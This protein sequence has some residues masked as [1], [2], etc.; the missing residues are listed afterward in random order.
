MVMDLLGLLEVLME[1]HLFLE[2]F[3]GSRKVSVGKY[4]T[5]SIS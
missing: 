4:P 1:L 2:G 5:A 3:S